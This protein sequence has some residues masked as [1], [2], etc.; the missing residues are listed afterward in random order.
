MADIRLLEIGARARLRRR[1]RRLAAGAAVFAVAGVAA[2]GSYAALRPTAP[3]PNGVAVGDDAPVVHIARALQHVLPTPTPGPVQAAGGCITLPI[4]YYHYIRVNPDP[5]DHLGFELSVTPP[6]F[7]AQMDWLRIAGAHPVTL[8][9]MMAALQGG[10]AL[11]SHPVVLTFDDGHDDFATQAVPVLMANHF[12]ATSFV[13]PGFL[14]TRGY[15]SSLQVQ[16][17]SADGMVIGAH[18]VHHV[19][20]THV[21]AAVAQAEITQSKALLEQL[22]GKPVLDFAYPYGSFTVPIAAMVQR[23]GFRDAAATTWGTQQC[24]SNRYALHRFEV[25]GSGSI[26]AVASDA[27]VP[28]PPAG[29]VDPGLPAA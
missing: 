21:S 23:A 15:M 10:P 28:G 13:V 1:A 4:L 11:P 12:V 22:I 27:G 18:T 5:R 20:L 26:A 16:Q 6:N 7:Q 9:Q 3:R 2:F 19:E 24:L 29:W 14:N 17:V 25:L 8:A